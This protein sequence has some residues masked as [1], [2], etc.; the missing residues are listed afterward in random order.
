V[1]EVK[2]AERPWVVL[3]ERSLATDELI[4]AWTNLT[5]STIDLVSL[6]DLA[7]YLD[8]CEQRVRHFLDALAEPAATAGGDLS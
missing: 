8:L 6:S 4:D 1:G 7:A 2:K 5:Y 3:R